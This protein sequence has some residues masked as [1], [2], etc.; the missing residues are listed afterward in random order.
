VADTALATAGW[1][2]MESERPDA[3]FHDPLAA[4]LAGARGLRLASSRPD[5][6]WVV[7]MRTPLIDDFLREA[8]S[9]GLDTIIDIGAG[10]DARPYRLDLPSSLRWIEIDDPSVIAAKTE[11]LRDEAP[12]CS[13]E[14]FGID[15]TDPDARR[16]VFDG[17]RRSSGRSMAL[18]EGLIGYLSEGEAAALADE[19]HALSSCELW[20]T[21]YFSTRLLRAYQ[22]HQPL[23]EAPVRFN[24]NDWTAFFAEHGWAVT[25]IGY[26]GERSRQPHRPVPLPFWDRVVRLFTSRPLQDTGYALLERRP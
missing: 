4:K 1:R 25:E 21:E 17:I 26:L 11:L 15:L 12:A 19:L 23:P 16:E 13:V 8:I 9:T 20:V 3:L 7:A 24:P 18:T 10:M 5:G 2:A 6:A 14:R 22:K